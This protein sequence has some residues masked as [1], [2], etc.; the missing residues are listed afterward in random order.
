MQ[1]DALGLDGDAA[2][3][4]EVHRVEHLRRH[5]A[6][7]QRAGQLQQPVGQ[8]G[9]AVVDVRDDAEIPDVLWVHLFVSSDAF[10]DVL[11]EALLRWAVRRQTR[12]TP[13]AR[14]QCLS[15]YRVCHSL[16]RGARNAVT[17]GESEVMSG[18]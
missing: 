14:Q 17:S 13:Q 8:R 12:S 7:A 16:N 18:E 4:L 1:A 11:A 9:L 10:S 2:L 3:A 5:F 6:L 15:N